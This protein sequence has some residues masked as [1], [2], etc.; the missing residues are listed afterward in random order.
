MKTANKQF[1]HLHVHTSYSLMNSLCKIDD[2]MERAKAFGMDALAITDHGNMYGAVKFCRA[3]ER[4]GIRPIIGYEAYVAPHPPEKVG[5]D[6][7]PYHLVLLVENEEGYK[8]LCQIA[9]KAIP[10]R[11]SQQIVTEDI[12]QKHSS[13]LIALSACHEGEVA[14]LVSKG[15]RREAKKAALKYMDIFGEGNFYLEIQDAGTSW[16]KDIREGILDIHKKTG[17]PIV[18]T[19]DVHFMAPEDHEAHRVLVAAQK[20]LRLKE[21]DASGWV[22]PGPERYF[23]SQAEM[24]ERFKDYPEALENTVKIAKRCKFTL[25]SGPPMYPKFPVPEGESH[26]S[27][28]TKLAENGLASKFAECGLTKSK[29]EYEQRLQKELEIIGKG[30]HATYILILWDCVRYIKDTE[31]GAVGPGR[32]ST[33]GS[34]VLFC[35]GITEVDP[36]EHGLYSELS[37]APKSN[38][39]LMLAMECSRV[40]EKKVWAYLSGKYGRRNV[41]GILWPH[42]YQERSAIRDVG[43]VMEAPKKVVVKLV[44]LSDKTPGGITGKAFQRQAGRVGLDKIALK[45]LG[46]SG[47]LVGI[48]LHNSV[49][50]SSAVIGPEPLECYCPIRREPY[51]IMHA[52]STQYDK[53][54]LKYLGFAKHIAITINLLSLY[55]ITDRELAFSFP[56]PRPPLPKWE[57]IPLDDPDT[58]KL[59]AKGSTAGVFPYESA[60]MRKLL[61]KIEPPAFKHLVALHALYRPRRREGGLLM[62]YVRRAR[63]EKP[64][65]PLLPELEPLLESTYGLIIYSEQVVEVAEKV[66]RF[67]LPEANALR[68]AISDSDQSTLENMMLPFIAGCIKSGISKGKARK[69]F[70][71]LVVQGKLVYHKSISLSWAIMAFRA[72]YLKAHFPIEFKR[73]AR[74]AYR[75]Y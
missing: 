15:K 73:A 5:E 11:Y 18:A 49:L 50:S 46:I 47:R 14:T 61:R 9:S 29:G 44:S 27:Y 64:A 71:H 48:G 20:G 25:K 8:S 28:L 3:A 7:R 70:Q 24:W 52:F 51:P 66:S 72:A 13:G 57:E 74:E 75:W 26:L 17:I 22:D 59:F 19:N 2:L 32:G 42:P 21:L 65:N 68:I 10:G 33:S 56:A 4:F 1:V 30:G 40:A 62:E 36:L 34:L 43:R 31:K 39:P 45:I 16:Q 23:K 38:L 35:L 55:A 69:L 37:L 54:D 63:G 6:S 60:E 12:L 58:L 53:E 41:T 67:T